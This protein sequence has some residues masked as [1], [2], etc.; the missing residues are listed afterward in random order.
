MRIALAMPFFDAA[1][2]THR[3]GDEEVVADELHA[4]AELGGEQLP[5]F[6]VVL[7]EAVLDGDD[8]VFRAQ[9]VVDADQLFAAAGFLSQV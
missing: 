7:G 6:P 8:G 9:R 2:E 5:A 3:V 4:A 1:R